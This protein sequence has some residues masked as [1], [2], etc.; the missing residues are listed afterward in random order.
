MAV[1]NVIE[2]F[3]SAA[4]CRGMVDVIDPGQHRNGMMV[5]LR[6]DEL[7]RGT[8]ACRRGWAKVNLT[9]IPIER[10]IGARTLR[11][12]DVLHWLVM[13]DDGVLY[14]GAGEPDTDVAFTPVTV[15]AETPPV[16]D[17]TY[18]AKLVPY[19]DD[20]LITVMQP[21]EIAVTP[22]AG[23]QNLRFNTTTGICYGMGRPTPPAP[24]PANQAAGTILDGNYDYYQT[25]ANPATG[26]ES[27]PS[28]IA[29]IEIAHPTYAEDAAVVVSGGAGGLAAGL[30]YYYVVFLETV[31]GMMSGLNSPAIFNCTGALQAALSSIPIC[32]DLTPGL[33]WHRL[34]FR[35]FAGG[36]VYLIATLAD[37]TTTVLADNAL[38]D[39]AVYAQAGRTIR[40]TGVSLYAGPVP[41]MYRNIYR[42]DNGALAGLLLPPGNIYTIEDNT[43]VVYDDNDV[44]HTD[45]E[46]MEQI[47]LPCCALVDIF[48]DGVPL[49][50]HDRENQLPAR[51]YPALGSGY[52]EA[53]ALFSPG[54]PSYAEA[55]QQTDELVALRTCRDGVFAYKRTAT[56]YLGRQ[57]KTCE[58]SWEGV[59]AVADQ[60]VVVIDSRVASLSASGPG[61]ISDRWHFAG[62]YD[63]RFCMGRFWET[64]VKDRLPYATAVHWRDA[65]IIIW[66]VQC[67]ADWPIDPP[68][69][70][71][72][73]VWEY[74][75]MTESMPGG[76]VWL[77]DFT[78]MD[79]GFEVPVAGCNNPQPFGAFAFGW[80]ARLFDGYHGDGTDGYLKGTVLGVSGTL[81]DVDT[82]AL[83]G[84]NVVGSILYINRGTGTRVCRPVSPCEN[85]RSL[86]ISQCGGQ[87]SLAGEL[88]IVAGDTFWIGGFGRRR[89]FALTTDDPDT[90]KVFATAHVQT[91]PPLAL[92]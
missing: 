30:F 77:M 1:S 23:T 16:W 79:C 6:N 52:P 56:Y 33:V 53:R 68:H 19:G 20:C 31:S 73:I 85:A 5:E 84:Q 24:V 80:V 35:S 43:T 47:G 4:G 11:V 88:S 28:P 18:T 65:G 81:V 71:V 37:N 58:R 44:E 17:G 7:H 87:F 13:G 75:V 70:E 61:Y 38:V 83:D 45:T 90:V 74:G 59:G 46:M 48:P 55:G 91:L 51:L 82:A 49:Y 3:F 22:A 60:T 67:C 66:F 34:I 10:A 32:P 26:W 78:G 50:A 29:S 21:Q 42:A 76:R 54:T 2:P 86:I 69:N 63:N 14:H 62:E 92:S 57:C 36:P 64:V 15:L 12:R 27:P 39:G 89:R 72:A 25:Y 41:G 9:R 8:W 40:L